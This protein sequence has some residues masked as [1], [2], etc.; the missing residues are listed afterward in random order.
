MSAADAQ[1]QDV[2]CVCVCVTQ[3][4]AAALGDAVAVHLA[5]VPGV[6][7]DAG[8]MQQHAAQ[9]S[10]SALWRHAEVTRG[11]ALH[12]RHPERHSADVGAV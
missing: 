6:E 2:V 3:L 10:Q 1:Q 12:R 8:R 5:E 7:A 4:M 9:A 11:V